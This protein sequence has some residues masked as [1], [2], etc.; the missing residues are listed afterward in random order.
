MNEWRFVANRIFRDDVPVR[1]EY[2]DPTTIVRVLNVLASSSAMNH[3]LLPESGGLDF[4]MQILL[5]KQG[6]YI[7]IQKEVLM[8]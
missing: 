6:L 8:S 2:Q 7:F 5:Q 1:T 3:M 4:L